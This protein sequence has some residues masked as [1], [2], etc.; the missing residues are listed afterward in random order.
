M[1]G[2]F[3]LVDEMAKKDPAVKVERAGMAA[4]ARRAWAKGKRP[5]LVIDLLNVVREV[6]GDLDWF[7]GGQ[8]EFFRRRMEVFAR[9]FTKEVRRRG[10]G[11]G[12]GK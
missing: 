10:R 12:K 9:R 2:F 5:V 7:C 6:W 11:G 4:E 3:K 1:T 8:F